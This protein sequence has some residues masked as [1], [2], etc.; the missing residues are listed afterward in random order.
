M[1]RIIP[2]LLCGL[3]LALTAGCDAKSSVQNSAEISES[4]TVSASAESKP[5]ENVKNS[6]RVFP[7]HL[8]DRAEAQTLYLSNTA[9][10]EQSSPYDL[11]YKS[12]QKDADVETLKAYGAKQMRE[13]SDSEQ[14]ALH[15]AMDEIEAIIKEKGVHLPQ[16]EEITFIR[17]TQFEECGTAYTHGTQIYMDGYIPILL[18][19]GEENH[20][21]GISVILHE[22]F[23]CLTRNNPTFRREMYQLIGFQIAD[24]E[25]SMP[26]EVAEIS[27]SNPDVERHDA[28]AAFTIGGKKVDCFLVL[29]ATKPFENTWDEV[30]DAM[31]IALVPVEGD[32]D[33]KAYYSMNDAEDFWEV[34][35]KNTDYV[36]DPEECMADNFSFALTYGMDGGIEYRTPEIIE[37]VLNLLS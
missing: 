19:A 14:E 28:Y 23:H 21:R 16:V 5:S 36:I 15:A 29:I 11:Q 25:F 13:F 8:A 32:A 9:Y 37:G 24:E 7:Y 18:K 1:R 10:F 34:F 30:G 17:S 22:L 4:T 3:M 12:K 35:G 26:A 33:G 20:R 2:V 31:D 6:D 27:I